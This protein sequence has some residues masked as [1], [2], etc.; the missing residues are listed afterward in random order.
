M[1]FAVALNNKRR[2]FNSSHNSHYQFCLH[3]MGTAI[4]SVA[5]DLIPKYDKQRLLRLTVFKLPKSCTVS[6]E[7]DMKEQSS[8]SIYRTLT[9][10]ISMRR[11]TSLLI[12]ST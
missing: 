4:S 11:Y 2:K 12:Y 7:V 9:M 5:R 8:I 1:I 10:N 3:L 6:Q